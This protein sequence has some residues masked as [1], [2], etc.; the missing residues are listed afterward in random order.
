MMGGRAIEKRLPGEGTWAAATGAAGWR[1]VRSRTGSSWEVRSWAGAL[2]AGSSQVG[3]M[4]EARF[5][6]VM[7]PAARWRGPL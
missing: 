6:E 4:R 5:G 7:S 3:W 1:A 2:R